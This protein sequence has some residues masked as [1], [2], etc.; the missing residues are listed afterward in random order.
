MLEAESLDAGQDD[1]ADS[2]PDVGIDQPNASCS[3]DA[4][5][6]A[7]VIFSD[8]LGCDRGSFADVADVADAGSTD[9][10]AEAPAQELV[11][12][13]NGEGLPP[14]IGAEVVPEPSDDLDE[15]HAQPSEFKYDELG[16]R[17]TL[18]NKLL[19]AVM[20][21]AKLRK[22]HG[23]QQD[24]FANSGTML[25]QCAS[26]MR[27]RA[28]GK[29]S[30]SWPSRLRSMVQRWG[31]SRASGRSR[32]GFL[33]GS[34]VR[35]LEVAFDPTVQGKTLAR[36]FG[37]SLSAMRE[38]V[39]I[40]AACRLRAQ[41]KYLEAL[42]DR[43]QQMRPLLTL[44]MLKFD[45]A[46]I[47]HALQLPVFL[48]HVMDAEQSSWDL[49]S[50]KRSVVCVWPDSAA[51]VECICTPTPMTGTCASACRM[52]LEDC[53]SASDVVRLVSELRE[54][55][56]VG[57][58]VR[59]A[60]GGYNNERLLQHEETRMSAQDG[61]ATTKVHCVNHATHLVVVVAKGM[62]SAAWANKL[63]SQ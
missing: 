20:H 30:C 4:D 18:Q 53:G 23:R 39:L 51:E 11:L 9:H 2:F 44:D 48:D 7:D 12:A 28:P 38:S 24:V 62:C 3:D 43:C 56:V 34:K 42:R 45:T 16:K 21:K 54:L 8:D 59:G 14:A 5:S 50:S 63:Y 40:V 13:G 36:S 27:P 32:K 57:L 6:F 49:M 52:A 15:A 41:L 47:K 46:K 31:M 10:E 37:M 22:A 17:T 35:D 19:S 33:W 55:A 1:D 25:L 61:V 29:T 58:A 60:D 26:L